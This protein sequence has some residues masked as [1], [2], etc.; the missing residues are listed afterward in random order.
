[1]TF[2]QLGGMAVLAFITIG[3]WLIP[4]VTSRIDRSIRDHRR[5][6]VR[7]HRTRPDARDQMAVFRRMN[8]VR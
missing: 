1:M 3:L 4:K 6:W 2:W 7:R 8:G 5:A